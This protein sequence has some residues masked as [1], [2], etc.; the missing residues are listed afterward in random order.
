MDNVS[1]IYKQSKAQ[2]SI[3]IKML[4]DIFKTHIICGYKSFNDVIHHHQIIKL[5]I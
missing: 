3:K 4:T 1:H 5:L 2:I